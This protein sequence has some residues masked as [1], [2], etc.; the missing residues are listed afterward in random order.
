MPELTIGGLTRTFTMRFPE[1][2]P[3]PL[4][5]ALH[6]NH[7]GATG[8]QMREWTEFDK[9][10][11]FAIA[12]PDGVGGC[13]ADGRGVTTADEAS[14]DDVAFLRAII[15][16]SAERHGTWPDGA[17]EEICRFAR[18]LLLPPGARQR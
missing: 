7:R 9:Q 1:E 14:V 12:Y 18:P 2:R 10:T 17:A 8:Q 13:W 11:D 6:G 15:D 3:A 4:L 5:L 16:W